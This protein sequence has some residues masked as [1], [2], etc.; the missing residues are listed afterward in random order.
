MKSRGVQDEGRLLAAAS[1]AADGRTG[2]VGALVYP[3]G[4]VKPREAVFEVSRWG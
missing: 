1:P 3:V 2:R 4:L